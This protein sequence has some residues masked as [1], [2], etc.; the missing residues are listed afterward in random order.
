MTTVRIRHRN[1]E[2]TDRHGN[3][4]V[5]PESLAWHEIEYRPIG[6]CDH[7]ETACRQ[8][9]EVWE[10]DYELD[11]PDLDDLDDLAGGAVIEPDEDDDEIVPAGAWG[12]DPDGFEDDYDDDY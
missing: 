10:L 6:S 9:L 3:V 7:Q 4:F 8:C 1:P 5:T 12:V 2:G 11:L